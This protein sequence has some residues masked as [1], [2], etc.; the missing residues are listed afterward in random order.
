MIEKRLVQWYAANAGI[1]LDIAEREVA[2]T[3]VLR[4]LADNG[5]L[6]RLAFKGGTAI[7]KIFLGRSGRFSLDLDFTAVTEESPDS[8]ILD[9][10][11]VLHEQVHHGLAFTVPSHDYYATPDS[12]GAE[13]VYRHDWVAAGHF[14]IQVRCRAQP[15]LPI[16]AMPLYAEHYFDWLG[17]EPPLVPTLDLHEVIGEKVRAAV[18]RTRVRDLYDLYQ[19]AGQRF[20][21]GLVRRITVLKCW[22]TRYA[23]EPAPFLAELPGGKYDWLDLQR[24]V[25]RDQVVP[26]D[27]VIQGVQRG[28]AFLEQLTPEEEMLAADPYG[29][30]RNVYAQLVSGLSDPA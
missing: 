28:F 13:I 10:V 18:Q 7:R 29:R 16:Q 1:D 8:L 23:F 4:I 15:L 30:E 17:I 3:Y 12:C 19:L 25:R 27:K 11:G 9:L 14:G 22:E 21:R 20:D 26:A 24:L 2:L 6:A 5:V